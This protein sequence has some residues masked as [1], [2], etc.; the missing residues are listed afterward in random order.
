MTE[1]DISVIDWIVQL[2]E[3]IKSIA[4]ET[5]IRSRSELI[6]GKW[7]IGERICNDQN[8]KKIAGSKDAVLKE[9]FKDSG[10]GERDGYY[11]VSFYGKYPDLRTAMH[12]F[13]EGNNISWNKVKTLYLTEGAEKAQSA[14]ELKFLKFTQEELKLIAKALKGLYSDGK[15]PSKAVQ[16]LVDKINLSIN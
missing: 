6:E 4:V 2:S 3:D 15:N 10:I 16:S 8:F 13:A 7:A 5:L 12:S 11:C 14:P 9:I 1:K